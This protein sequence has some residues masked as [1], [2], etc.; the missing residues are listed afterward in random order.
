MQF[1]LA[2][3]SAF[4]HQGSQSPLELVMD[5]LPV[6]LLVVEAPFVASLSCAALPHEIDREIGPLG[7]VE[8]AVLD[9]VGP[10]V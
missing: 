10:V 5:S 6:F 9:R 3:G 8:F 1:V 4:F 2:L 7:N